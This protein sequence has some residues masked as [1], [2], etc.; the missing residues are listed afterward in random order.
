MYRKRRPGRAQ[1]QGNLRE[2]QNRIGKKHSK[3]RFENKNPRRFDGEKKGLRKRATKGD[4]KVW[5]GVK[6][7]AC[8]IQTRTQEKGKIQRTRRR[9][10]ISPCNGRSGQAQ[11][12]GRETLERT[13][14]AEGGG[15]GEG[16][17]VKRGTAWGREAK[18]SK[19]G[20]STVNAW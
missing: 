15:D 6:V 18:K 11:K 17:K 2:K 4:P 12:L 16:G 13:V 9:E 14:G 8:R 5:R 7:T 3:K 20:S 10:K 1:K 19:L